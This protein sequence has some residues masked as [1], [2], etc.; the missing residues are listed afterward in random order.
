VLLTIGRLSRFAPLHGL[1][2][3]DE[4]EKKWL[5]KLPT[6]RPVI[7]QYF[8]LGKTDGETSSEKSAQKGKKTGSIPR[9]IRQDK[10]PLGTT[11]ASTYK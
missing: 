6:R 2:G 10:A 7:S 9:G 1:E 8:L 11:L 5:V 4:R 3:S